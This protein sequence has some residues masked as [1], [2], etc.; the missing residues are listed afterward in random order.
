MF[1]YPLPPS[2]PGK[3]ARSEV[4]GVGVGY[5]SVGEKGG[6]WYGSNRGE[7]GVGQCSE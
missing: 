3:G 5:L 2:L 1:T 7:A 6:A 4:G